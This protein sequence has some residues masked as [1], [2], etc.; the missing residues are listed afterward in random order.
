MARMRPARA[1]LTVAAVTAAVAASL[2]GVA[3]SVWAAAAGNGTVFDSVLSGAVV[4]SFAVVGAV[5]AAA[6]PD[7]RVGWLMLAGGTC[8]SL[9]QAGCDLAYLGIVARPGSVPA[10]SFFADAGS[11]VRALGWYTVTIAVPMVFPDG[12]LVSRR[13]RILPWALGLVMLAAIF[14][15]LT[16]VQAGLTDLAGSSWHNPV[17]TADWHWLSGAAFLV[18]VPGGFLLTLAVVAQLVV[19]WRRGNALV[20]QQVQLFATAVG[21]TLVAFPIAFGTGVGWAFSAAALPLPFAIGFAVLA[22]GLYDLRTAVNRTLL[23]VT[24]SGLVAAAYAVV[25]AGVGAQLHVR[26]A[27]WLSWLAAGVIAVSFAPL[28]D[29]LQRAI[30]RVT[31]G[32]WDEPY[33]VLAALG[34]RLE[35]SADV[36]RLL[37]D[38]VAELHDAGARRTCRDRGPL[39]TGAGR[40]RARAQV[41]GA[42]DRLRAS[43]SAPCAT[44]RPDARCGSGTSGCSTTSPATSAASLH[45][46][47][48]T[49]DLQ[50]AR[51]RLVLAREE[52]RR[53]LRRDLHDGLGPALAGLTCC[54]WTS[55]ARPGA[56][57]VRRARPTSAPCAPSCRRPCSRY[58]GSSRGCDRRPSTSS[59]SAGA[60]RAGLTGSPPAAASSVERRQS[61]NCPAVRPRWR[62]RRTGSSPR[63]S[64][65]SSASRAPARCAVSRPV[66]G[67]RACAGRRRRRAAACPRG[68]GPPATGCRRCASGPRSCAAGCCRA[69]RPG[70]TARRRAAVPAVSGSAAAL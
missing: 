35:G 17:P 21:V 51:E 52:E 15:P 70:T 69:A 54:G 3:A 20:R 42:A 65:T 26:G 18:S 5:V 16:D 64:R 55:C 30:N 41:G 6:R 43:R 4:V 2:V 22:R 27:A 33:D 48:L 38:V 31:Y 34:Q 61:P 57:P 66:A 9:G 58:G 37:G 63:R 8:W 19:R 46:H 13:W 36:D 29:G 67:R 23:W 56:A 1:Q 25:V 24:L 7:N 47:R 68:R 40:G 32:R 28:R 11:A 62:S 50:R 59:V 44:G 60:H 39:R 10:V 53:R 45:A 49:A 12:R 14:D